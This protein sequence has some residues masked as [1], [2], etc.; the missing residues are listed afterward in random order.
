M[1]IKSY[2]FYL[3][4]FNCIWDVFCILSFNLNNKI[5]N[6]HLSI[7]YENSQINNKNKLIIQY[8]VIYWSSLRII[9]IICNLKELLIFSYIF[10]GLIFIKVLNKINGLFISLSSFLIALIIYLYY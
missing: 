7:L 3:I 6:I 9:G 4:F 1:N 5:S 8:F 10:E 2:L